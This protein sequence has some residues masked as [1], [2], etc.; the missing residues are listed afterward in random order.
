MDLAEKIVAE[1]RSTLTIRADAVH[2]LFRCSTCSAQ[3]GLH[4]VTV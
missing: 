4:G 2:F 1:I 3:V